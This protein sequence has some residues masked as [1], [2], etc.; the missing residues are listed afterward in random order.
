MFPEKV[1]G[2]L[3]RLKRK[4]CLSR[5]LFI[6][7]I[8]FSAN[9]AVIGQ[10]SDLN[11]FFFQAGMS[12]STIQNSS[13]S[14]FE[15]LNIKAGLGYSIPLENSW[16]ISTELSVVQ[17][18]VR[19]LPDGASAVVAQYRADLWY[20]QMAGL[21]TYRIGE[22]FSV[23][24]GP[25]VGYLMASNEEDYNGKIPDD[26][27]TDYT[28]FELSVI[29]SFKYHITEKMAFSIWIDQSILPVINTGLEDNSLQGVRQYNTV[30]GG[31]VI[32]GF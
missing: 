22:D 26:R 28:S 4:N 9:G 32:V 2:R 14:G 30:A 6:L 5:S 11:T 23:L 3:C 31:S 19:D 21:C 8:S 25:A 12:A 1:T 17:K 10:Q 16:G 18:G 27:A 15:K 20:L 29:A 7:L 24:L 13:G